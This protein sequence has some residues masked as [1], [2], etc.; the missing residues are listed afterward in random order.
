M[1]RV[2]LKALPIL[3]LVAALSAC[4]GGGGG[5][6]SYSGGDPIAVSVSGSEA[7]ATTALGSLVGVRSDGSLSF[8]GVRFAAS[9]GGDR[10]W[11]PPQPSGAWTGALD[12]TRFGNQCPSGNSLQAGAS[13]DCLY[14]N[15]YVPETVAGGTRNLPVMF[16]I[17]G[18]ANASGSASD[19]DPS[20][21]VR[22]E[23]VIVVTTNYRVGVLGFL[24]HPSI[25]AESHPAANYGLLDQQLALRWV[26][27]NIHSFGGDPG[28]VTV[29]GASSGGLNILNHLISPSSLGL[30][31]K[32]IV[33]SG[34]YQPFTPTLASSQ[35]RGTAFANRLGC[36]DQ[37]AACLRGKPLAEIL[38]NQGR[39]NAASSAF[40]QSTV[41]GE[42][43]PQAQ[44]SAFLEGKFA[45]VPM[46]QGTTRYEGRAIPSE[47]PGMTAQDFEAVAGNYATTVAKAPG[48]I[49]A[50]Y[51]LGQYKDPFEA[52]SAVV[53]DAAFACP[54]LRSDQIMS[55][56]APV[57]AYEFDEGSA[58]PFASGHYA[59]VE[60]VFRVSWAP[61][62]AGTGLGTTIR[63]HFARFARTGDP[64]EA[65]SAGWK[66]FTSQ[67]RYMRLIAPRSERKQDFEGEHRCMFWGPD[68]GIPVNSRL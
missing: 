15:V 53:T 62:K 67:D 65:G 37:S 36:A 52:A 35:G 5:E 31:H 55:S 33:Q 17:H 1:Q 30:F 14:L 8:K 20:L 59:D 18:G 3:S 38:A 34:A 61:E 25:D 45:K 46:M 40:N 63:R 47:F 66:P 58:D 28:N 7:R 12:A 11:R 16:W 27:D 23:G 41:D 24:A 10:R 51:P 57:F 32:A 6:G 19:Y 29:F 60:Y 26:K 13:E 39:T 56:H 2:R 42:V 44:R 64:N 9:T 49:L 4:G 22:Q 68:S 43:I 21:L 48:E 54:A 50:E